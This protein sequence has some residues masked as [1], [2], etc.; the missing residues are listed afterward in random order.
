MTDPGPAG[1]RRVTLRDR[2]DT[3]GTRFL[4]ATLDAGTLRI[5]GQDLGDAVE[6]ILGDREYEW[7]WTVAAGDL[8]AAIEALG[9]APGADP[10]AVL[11]AWSAANADA[12]PGQAIRDAGTPIA[13]WSRLGD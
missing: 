1:G 3:G 2:R 13:F 9:A 4:E 12:D 8:P 11:Q 7:T 10:L 5:E 6:A